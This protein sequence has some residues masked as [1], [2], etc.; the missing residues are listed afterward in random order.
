MINCK[1]ELKP[2]WKKYCVLY[3][4]T[5][6]N[7]VNYN[8]NANNI[9]FTVKDTKLYVAVVTLSAKDNKNCQNFLAKELKDQFIG[10]NIKQKV[11]IK[12]QQTNLDIFSNQTLLELIDLFFQL[13]QMKMPLLKDLKLKD[14]IY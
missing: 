11:R 10:V 7:N 9:I 1:V 5:A 2:K 8:N 6:E 13:I 12:I 4:A 14:I 3:V